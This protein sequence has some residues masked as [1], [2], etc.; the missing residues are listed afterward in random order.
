VAAAELGPASTLFI[1]KAAHDSKK[2]RKVLFKAGSPRCLRSCSMK[3]VACTRAGVRHLPGSCRSPAS[4]LGPGEPTI[5]PDPS[6]KSYP[7]EYPCGQ[8]CEC[9]ATDG[10]WPGLGRWAADDEAR[11]CA[12][13]RSSRRTGQARRHRA[14]AAV[15]PALQSRGDGLFPRLSVKRV[16]RM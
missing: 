15:V 9:E 7:S 11:P 6:P 10:L 13:Q 8:S 2:L 3:C 14:G 16:D 1:G 12:G 4:A 5:G